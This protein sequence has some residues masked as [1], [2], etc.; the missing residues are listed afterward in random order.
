MSIA[1]YRKVVQV[2]TTSATAYNPIPG[3]TASLNFGGELLD[4]TNFT[5]TG[6]RSRVRGLK[7]YSVPVTAIY[8]S[9]DSALAA[10]RSA[11]LNDT[12]LDIQYLPNGTAGFS[13]RVRVGSFTMSG[14]VG[15]LESV[16]IDMQATD[17]IA[18]STV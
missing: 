8:S 17:Q 4:D 16:D 12:A 5:S 10:I 7:D 15:G 14:D 18:L 9:T 1:G 13:G 2:K 3:N 11:L 6:W